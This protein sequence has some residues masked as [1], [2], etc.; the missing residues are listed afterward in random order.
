M[1]NPMETE[2][3]TAI[4][5]ALEEER[6]IEEMRSR[7]DSASILM[8]HVPDEGLD[9]FESK[10]RKPIPD[11]K[12][13]ASPD[14]IKSEER[15]SVK[16]PVRPKTSLISPE[17]K[18]HH[19]KK[20]TMPAE[21]LALHQSETLESTLTGLADAMR[22]IHIESTENADKKEIKRGQGH[23][24]LP[25][26]DIGHPAAVMESIPINNADVLV[27][28]ANLLL[29]RNVSKDDSSQV[30]LSRESELSSVPTQKPRTVW[31]L[32]ETK[33]DPKKTDG[34]HLGDDQEDSSESQVEDESVD[35]ELISSESM[36]SKPDETGGVSAIDIEE[37][38]R[39]GTEGHPS[40]PIAFGILGTKKKNG[41]KST[42]RVFDS[43]KRKLM[44]GWDMF[45]DFLRP[46]RASIAMYS[47]VVFLFLLP[48]MAGVAATLFYAAGNP[49]M[50]ANG[51]SISWL[52]LFAA[53]QVV[54]LTL[55]KATSLLV[56]DF[57]SL[58]TR[59]TV[60]LFG[61]TIAL[62]IVQSKGF[63][64]L[65]AVWSIYDFILL[66]GGHSFAN[67]WLFWQDL[68]AMSNENNP[69]GGI[70][71]SSMNFRILGTALAVGIVVSIKRVW[72][73]LYLGRRT[74]GKFR[75]FCLP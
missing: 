6:R 72:V 45:L 38:R 73:G 30:G 22:M 41:E 49:V 68:I 8:P 15:N 32:F 66:S 71:S 23:R 35:N 69:S 19:R 43:A 55:S 58:R 53:R 4:I 70:T 11:I 74:F 50:T 65:L 24:R 40:R 62:F 25:S 60:R 7:S 31:N 63:P 10:C 59:W 57:W 1:G 20:S 51:A 26:R 61:P 37:G 16:P 48:S 64:F 56:I 36:R 28:N 27:H 42:G 5:A 2:A 39:D 9:M 47:R 75:Q 21:G 17:G 14:S 29:R 3:E 46:E 44:K 54:T 12:T 13:A 33:P 67:H 52:L 18:T 34:D